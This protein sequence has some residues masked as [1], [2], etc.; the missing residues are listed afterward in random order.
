MKKG[1]K[2]SIRFVIQNLGWPFIVMITT[3]VAGLFIPPEIFYYIALLAGAILI[4]SFLQGQRRLRDILMV[5]RLLNR[6][7]HE[8]M[9]ADVEYGLLDRNYQKWNQE[10]RDFFFEDIKTGGH[11]IDRLP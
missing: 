10:E 9:D 6:T 8:T 2:M 7:F 4:I 1:T 11:N 5:S 3:G